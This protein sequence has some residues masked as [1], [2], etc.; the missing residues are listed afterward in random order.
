MAPRIQSTNIERIKAML[1]D[2]SNRAVNF[3]SFIPFCLSVCMYGGFNFLSSTDI[4]ATLVQLTAVSPTY[5]QCWLPIL[6]LHT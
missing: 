3:S 4:C 1:I 5:T 2:L 6:V